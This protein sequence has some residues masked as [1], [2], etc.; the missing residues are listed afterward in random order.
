MVHPRFA[1][2]SQFRRIPILGPFV[3]RLRTLIQIRRFPGTQS[4]WEHRYAEGGTSGSG[5][6]GD[7]AAFKAA[8]L[9]TLVLREEVASVIEFGCGDGNQLALAEY[10]RYAG[11]DV[12]RSAIGRCIEHFKQDSGKSFLLY[13]PHFFQNNGTLVADL[14]LSLDVLYH[15]IE[16]DVWEL[17]LRHLFAA[18]RHL[19]AIYAVD[20]DLDR[21]GSHVL[22]R[23]FTPWIA[24]TFPEWEFLSR[25]E[26]P[27]SFSPIADTVPQASFTIYRRASN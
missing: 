20:D 26:H 1:I 2:L 12:S 3:T 11:L 21:R 22:Y 17:H 9:N 23:R 16:V 25:I 19:V 7:L 6:Y 18:S 4:Y 8:T 15:L 24:A 13:E 5:S 27:V 14:S 10:P